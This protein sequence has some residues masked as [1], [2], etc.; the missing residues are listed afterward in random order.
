MSVNNKKRVKTF[1]LHPGKIGEKGEAN[2]E[3]FY[4][5]S[6]LI[7]IRLILF[8]GNCSSSVNKKLYLV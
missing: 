8:L 4:F 6:N 2:E 7:G 3:S 1:G 5:L